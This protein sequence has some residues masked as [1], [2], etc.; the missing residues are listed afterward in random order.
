M[1]P[2]RLAWRLA[3]GALVTGVVGG[4]ATAL[5]ALLFAA[6]DVSPGA[7]SLAIA[8][9]VGLMAMIGWRL[10]GVTGHARSAPSAGWLG[11][12]ATAG[13][14]LIVV[15][16]AWPT[17]GEIDDISVTASGALA[18]ALYGAAY[19]LIPALAAIAVLGLVVLLLPS[20]RAWIARP[21]AQV[22]LTVLSMAVTAAFSLWVTTEMGTE[23]VAGMAAALAGTGVA[24]TA[25][26]VW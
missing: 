15:V 20:W 21:S 18:L 1:E 5:L 2:R 26:R 19:G 14:A 16:Q 13:V 23:S 25:R 8:V 11:W 4:M 9:P 12:L 7:R 22:P 24:L 17:T 10:A 6:S 3:A